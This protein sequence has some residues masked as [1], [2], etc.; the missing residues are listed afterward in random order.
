MKNAVS[1]AMV[2]TGTFIGA[3]FASG[4]EV[5]QYFGIFGEY[6]IFGIL[7]SCIILVAF[8]YCTADNIVCLGEKNYINILCKTKL[9]NIILNVYMLI[10]FSTMIT[11]FGESL[12]QTFG[13]PKV[14]G[15]IFMNLV[16]IMIL[17]FG[18]GGMIK[19]NSMVT[20]LIIIGIILAD[21]SYSV[22]AYNN[23]V[24]SAIIYTSYNVISFP[25]VMVGMKDMFLK[26][27]NIIICS[28]LFGGIIFV[29]ALCILKLLHGADNT[30]S[31]P[32]LSVVSKEYSYFLIVVLAM[33]MLTT[34]VSN[35]YGFI[36]SVTINKKITLPFLGVFAFLFSFFKF[37]FIVKYLYGFFGYTGLYILLINF[38]IFIKNREKPR[39]L[40]IKCD[41]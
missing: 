8:T 23:F 4:Q 9:V 13:F 25:F 33:S 10:I 37:G 20:P 41:N 26:K 24:T 6:G 21:Y 11:A 17:Y 22:F 5:W 35:G 18:A 2:L 31:I 39:K 36:N 40:K 12:N 32:I 38:C 14:Y 15:V 19:L 27:K 30:V 34:A 7:I 16:T 29:L 1:V 28:L 3:G